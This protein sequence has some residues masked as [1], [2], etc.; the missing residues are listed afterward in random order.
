MSDDPSPHLAAIAPRVAAERYG[1][2]V[3]ADEH[4][5]PRRQPDAVRRR[6][7]C[8]HPRPDRSRP[9]GARRVPA[10]RR[11]RQPDLDPPGVRGPPAQPVEPDLAPDQARRARRLLLHHLRRRPRR[12]RP[13]RRRDAGPARQARRGQVLRIVAACRR[14]SPTTPG[15]TPTSAGARADDWVAGLRAER[16]SA[17]PAVSRALITSGTGADQLGLRARVVA[18]APPGPHGAG[19]GDARSRRSSARCS[20][21]SAS[22]PYS[23]RWVPSQVQSSSPAVYAPPVGEQHVAVLRQRDEVEQ[24]GV[25]LVDRRARRVRRVARPRCSSS[26]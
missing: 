14:R 24:V 21:W 22:A 2:D 10:R 13:R 19:T 7:P 26:R 9:H 8:G 6:R 23:V 3:L 4:R 25:V 20:R 12:R 11:A 17:V 18:S 5:G 16:R 15:P 1:L